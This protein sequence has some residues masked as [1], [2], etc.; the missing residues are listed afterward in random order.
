MQHMYRLAV[1]LVDKCEIEEEG[2]RAKWRLIRSTHG[3]RRLAERLS[4]V[5]EGIASSGTALEYRFFTQGHA[6]G[7]PLYSEPWI[8][9]YLCSRRPCNVNITTTA[10]ADGTVASKKGSWIRAVRA[11]GWTRSSRQAAGVTRRN[12]NTTSQLASGNSLLP[13]RSADRTQV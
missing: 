10:A 2:K 13:M 1:R 12:L 9:R 3:N 8:D 7:F 4:W 5:Y 6:H 11:E